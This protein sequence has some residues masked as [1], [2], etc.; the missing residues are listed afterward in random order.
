VERDLPIVT[1]IMPVHNEALY[2]RRA[3]ESVLNQDYPPHLLDILIFDGCSTDTTR[4]IVNYLIRSYGSRISLLDNP[5]RAVPFAMNRGLA[6]APGEVIVR[7][8]GHC[9]LPEDYISTCVDHL[10]LY[11]ADAVGGRVIAQGEGTLAQAVAWAMSS[12]FGVGVNYFRVGGGRRLVDTIAFAAHWKRQLLEVGKFQ[13]YLRQNSDDE[14]N[15]RFREKGF[16]FLLLPRMEII[17]WSRSNF[18]RLF[19]QFLKYGYYKLPV[20]LL[21]PHYASIRHLLPAFFIAW[22]IATV[23]TFIIRPFWGLLFTIPYILYILFVW[24]YALLAPLARSWRHRL[25]F[26]LVVTTMHIG[27]GLGF[28]WSV[29]RFP[30]NL[31]KIRKLF[32]SRTERI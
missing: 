11:E 32:S 2:V 23:T 5:E 9:S 12:R 3:V 6:L 19:Q 21:H 17:Y 15:F 24:G 1:V 13:E 30:F 20:L 29:L 25:L 28:F 14:F 4:T 10:L 16:T 31:G 18:L 22:G 27:Y 8:D 7:L 26:P